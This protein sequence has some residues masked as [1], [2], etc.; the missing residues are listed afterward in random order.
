MAEQDQERLTALQAEREQLEKRLLTLKRD[1]SRET[2]RVLKEKREALSGSYDKRLRGLDAEIRRI[3]DQRSR[4]RDQG[5]KARIA[6][7][8]EGLSGENNKLKK[9]LVNLFRDNHVPAICRSG[10]FYAWTMPRGL[11]EILFSL[12]SFVLLFGIL[13]LVIHE[14]LGLN[15]FWHWIILYLLDILIFGGLYILCNNL[16]L[17]YLSVMQKGRGIRNQIRENEKRIRRIRREIR[18]DRDDAVY[19]LGAFDDELAK[20]TG[21]R[22]QIQRERQEALEQFDAVTRTVLSDEIAMKYEKDIT[23]VSGQLSDIDRQRKELEE[24]IKD[25]GKITD[26]QG[27]L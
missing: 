24:K 14:L 11:G 18:R 16:K 2:D 5:V 25:Y 7:Q 9:D 12:L 8:T 26:N 27:N 19:E 17:R 6:G 22:E 23:A 10:P 4:A 21:D 13:P 20:K 3:S 1:R 15:A